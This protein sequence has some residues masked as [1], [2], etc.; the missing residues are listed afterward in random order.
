MASRAFSTP[1][2]LPSALA[3]RMKA[4]LRG[5]DFAT[6]LAEDIGTAGWY[7]GLG[8]MLGGIGLALA[9]WPGIATGP[10]IPS[11]PM[12]AT[13]REQ[14]RSQ[15]V[16]PLLY[17]G[18][19]GQRMGPT[20]RLVPLAQAPER[21]S[22]D[23]SVMLAQEDSVEA[24]LG[25]AGVSADDVA[26]VRGALASAGV[27]DDIAPGTRFALHLGRAAAPDRP[28]LL[29]SLSLRARFDLD[30]TLTRSAGGFAVVRHVLPVDSTPLRIRGV[31]GASVYRAARAAGAPMKAIQQF[32]AAIDAHLSLDEVHQGDVFDMVVDYK[33]APDGQVEVGELQYASIES[34]GRMAKQLLRWG[35]GRDAQ[36]YNASDMVEQRA[37]QALVM[38]V[39]G[40]RISS[41]F[42]LRLHPI[43]GFA[44]MHSGTDLAAP[45]GAPVYAVA[46]ALVNFVGPHG[47]HGNYI[48]LDHGGAVSTGYGHLSRFAVSPGMRVRAGQVIGYVGSTGLST[49]AHL[50]YEVFRGGAA[51]D[52]MSVGF[53]VRAGVDRAEL[54]AFR[55]RLAAVLHVKPSEALGPMGA[56]MAMGSVPRA[57]Y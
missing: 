14:W 7:R 50:H 36:F 44:R 48:R 35:K 54:A 30:L 53:T 17:G 55:A 46:D 33:R 39:A 41:G 27:L 4:G 49:G 2:A 37:T 52:P 24:M 42:G 8:V 9:L 15:T 12:D 45:W 51:V 20:S 34:H 43:L 11:Q 47:G 18:D 28:R 6:D 1:V 22:I 38:P 57:A 21:P 31:A 32:L 29:E 10:T 19:T 16:Q 25:R 23:L 56:Y 26:A 5:F 13:A 40:A 3:A